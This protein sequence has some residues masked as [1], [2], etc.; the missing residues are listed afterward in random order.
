MRLVQLMLRVAALLIL[1]ASCAR[2][3]TVDGN[4]I[5]VIDG[6]TI[7]LPCAK[8]EAGCSEHIRFIDIDAPESFRSHC[9][10]E[11]AAGLK[12]KARVVELIRGQEVEVHRSGRQDRYRR[13]LAN[14]SVPAGDVGAI[15]LKE[16]LARPYK[17]GRP[18]HAERIAS[19]CGP[20]DW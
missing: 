19:W 8:P 2:A 20:G 11:L 9:P 12:A 18:A 6:D 17:P 16:G 1:L 14:I 3:E 4:R 7:G 10:D 15:L 13:T 5:V